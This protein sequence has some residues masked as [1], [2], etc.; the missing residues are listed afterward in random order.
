MIGGTQTARQGPGKMFMVWRGFPG[1]QPGPLG[2]INGQ[3]YHA[4]TLKPK[5]GPS[6]GEKG[7]AVLDL[8]EVDCMAATTSGQRKSHVLGLG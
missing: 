4:L 5:R 8:R 1:A 7:Y 2:R 6:A 3:G